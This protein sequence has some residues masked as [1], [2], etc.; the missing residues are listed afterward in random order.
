MINDHFFLFL[1]IL[2][3]YIRRVDD[4]RYLMKSLLRVTWDVLLLLINSIMFSRQSN[5]GNEERDSQIK[6]DFF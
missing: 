6:Y 1:K 4:F 5:H 2:K 3:E